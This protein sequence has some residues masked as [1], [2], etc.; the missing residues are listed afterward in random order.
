MVCRCTLLETP[1]LDEIIALTEQGP[2][3]PSILDADPPAQRVKLHAGTHVIRQ[4]A[5]VQR[6]LEQT[7]RLHALYQGADRGT[8]KAQ[9][10]ILFPVARPATA[11]GGC[12]LIMISGEIKVLPRPCA[13]A[14]G[15]LVPARIIR[16]PIRD[17][18][19]F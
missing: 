16:G 8:A 1:P 9:D 12:W 6:P 13:R 11:P 15:I 19:S 14:L 18:V 2:S 4:A 5:A 10:E 3:T 17:Q 7:G